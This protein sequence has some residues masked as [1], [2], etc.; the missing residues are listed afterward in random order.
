MSKE[1]FRE[2]VQVL[3]H[4]DQDRIQ[5]PGAPAR[6]EIDAQFQHQ[7][8]VRIRLSR[9]PR[10]KGGRGAHSGLAEFVRS[11]R[12]AGSGAPAKTG[13]TTPSTGTFQILI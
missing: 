11:D 4:L 12:V 3:P 1:N 7:A 6:C 13:G 5:V 10:H 9:D 2:L 8:A